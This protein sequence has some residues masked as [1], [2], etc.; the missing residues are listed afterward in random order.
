LDENYRSG[1]GLSNTVNRF[2][3]RGWGHLL[4]ENLTL[5]LLAQLPTV[6]QIELK[7]A[8]IQK[9]VAKQIKRSD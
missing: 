8:S 7:R 2:P 9:D 5:K 1:S 4:P 3:F 6:V